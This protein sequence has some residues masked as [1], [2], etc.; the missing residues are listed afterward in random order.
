MSTPGPPIAVFVTARR[1]DGL[2]AYRWAALHADLTSM[3][4]RAGGVVRGEWHSGP[5]ALLQSACWC[6]EIQPGIAGR[7]QELL[8]EVASEHGHEGVAWSEVPAPVL[9]YGSPSTTNP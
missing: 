5:L 1:D 7:L 2:S 3:M 8:A 4:V 6:I 9:L